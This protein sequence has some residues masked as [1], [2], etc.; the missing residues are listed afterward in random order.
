[1]GQSRFLYISGK[2]SLQPVPFDD[3]KVAYERREINGETI[4]S[5][6][7]NFSEDY[8]SSSKAFYFDLGKSLNHTFVKVVFNKDGSLKQEGFYQKKANG[9]NGVEEVRPEYIKSLLSNDTTKSEI[10]KSLL[11]RT[12]NAN[13]IGTGKDEKQTLTIKGVD[14]FNGLNKIQAEKIPEPVSYEG[15]KGKV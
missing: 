9:E 11:K 14:I 7:I 12:I 8:N 13:C 2:L 6:S 10:E 5:A 15:S 3:N 4:Q 1:M